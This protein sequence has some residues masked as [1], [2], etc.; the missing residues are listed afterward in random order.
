MSGVLPIALE[1]SVKIISVMT[2]TLK[3]YIALMELHSNVSENKIREIVEMFVGDIYQRP[4]LR[5]SVKRSLRIR[6]IHEIEILDHVERWVLMRV[7]TDPGTYIRKLIHD[8]GLLLGVGAHMREL[9]RIKTGIFTEDLNMI[10]LHQLSEAVYL[11]NEEKDETLLRK[12]VMPIEYGVAHLPK[13]FINTYAVDPV[14]RGAQL[15]VPGVLMF[16]KNIRR[17]DLIA[18]FTPK[19]ELVAIARAEMNSEEILSRDK[20]IVSTTLR[21]IMK[22]G[23]YPRWTRKIS[24]E[25]AAAGI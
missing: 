14:S 12:Y 9:R 20:G 7:K 22:P 16:D 6:K 25:K 23:V 3:E 1:D 4:P 5:S 2:H 11:Y 17:G 21:V 8:I 19:S 10:T 13:I 18:I 24:D 15:A